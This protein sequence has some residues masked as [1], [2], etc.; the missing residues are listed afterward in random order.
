M[1]YKSIIL[2]L[3]ILCVSLCSFANNDAKPEKRKI[4]NELYSITIPSDWT[5]VQDIGDGIIPKERN[6]G[7]YHLYYIGWRAKRAEIIENTMFFYIQSY[8]KL[9]GSPLSIK[10]VEDMNLAVNKTEYVR[11]AKLTDLKA[12]PGQRRYMVAKEELS[13]PRGFR[14]CRNLCLIQKGLDVVHYLMISLSEDVYQKQPGVQKLINEIL[15]SF[16]V[17]SKFSSVEHEKKSR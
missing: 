3:S 15:D 12:K 6:G 14:K 8:R 16:V 17:N 2:L 9:D 4:S 11:N 5:P 10:E 13:I 1:T 7:P